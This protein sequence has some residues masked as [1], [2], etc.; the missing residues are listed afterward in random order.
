MIAQRISELLDLAREE[1]LRLPYP[2]DYICWL[3]DRS[4]VV[5]LIDGDVYAVTVAPT[6]HA[7]AVAYLLGHEVGELVV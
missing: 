3:E 4:F 1:G 2:P 6:R 7:Q 5:D